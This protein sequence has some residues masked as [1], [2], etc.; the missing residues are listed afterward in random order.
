MK[1]TLQI[2]NNTWGHTARSCRQYAGEVLRRAAPVV[3]MVVMGAGSAWGQILQVTGS[4]QTATTTSTTLTINKPSGLAVGD[5]MFANIIQTDNDAGTGLNTNAS[6]SGW[7]V[8]AGNQIG[9][10]GNNEWWGTL[11]YKIADAADVMAANFAFT[12]DT[13][14]NGDGSAGGIV[15]FSGVDTGFPFDAV[16]PGVFNTTVSDDLLATGITTTT[17][18][19]AV[20]MFGMN[21]ANETFGSWTTTAPGALAEVFEQTFASGASMGAAAAWGTL[22]T[23]GATGNGTAEMSDNDNDPNGALLIALRPANATITSP[24]TPAYGGTFTVPA[25][26]T[27]V[28]V[29]AWGGGGGGG[30]NDTG[31][32]SGAD[33]AGGGGGGGYR[34]GVLIVSPGDNITVAIGAAGAG[35]PNTTN[36]AGTAGG[37]STVTHTSGVI[38]ANGGTAGTSGTA[39]GTGGGGSFSGTVYGQ[40]AFAGG[41][42]GGGDAN[43]GGGGGGSAGS[44]GNGGNGAN[45]TAGT[46]GAGGGAAGGAGGDDGAGTSGSLPGG[47]GGGAGDEGGGGG[48][49]AYGQVILTWGSLSSSTAGTITSGSPASSCTSPFNPNNISGDDPAGA[50]T[51]SWQSSTDGGT[52]W[53][54]IGGATSASYDPGNITATTQYRRL[55]SVSGECP[56]ISNVVTYSVNT[57]PTA[58]A[59]TTASV[60]T[61]TPATIAGNPTGGSGMYTTHAWTITNAGGTGATNGA[62]LT[63]ANQET[64]TFNGTGLTAGTVTLQY[65][66]TDNNGCTGTKTVAV[67]V[68]L[69]LAITGVSICAGGSGSLAVTSACADVSGSEGPSFAGTGTNVTGVGTVAWTNPGNIVSDNGSSATASRG[70]DG[71]VTT[72]YLQG[73]NLGFTIPSGA[74]INGIQV[75]M[76]RFASVSSGSDNV[77]DNI[78]RLIKAGTVT[79][80][81]KAVAGNWATAT[82]TVVSYGGASDLWGTTWTPAQIN[83]S[84]FGAALS[85]NITR[86]NGIVTGSVD[87]ISITVYYTIDHTIS[88]YTVSSGGTAVQTESSLTT[89]NPVGDAEV[90]MAGAPYSSLNN[91]NT[92][93]TYTFWAEC[94]LYPDCRTAVDFVINPGPSCSITGSDP[95]CANSTGH[96]YMGSGGGTYSWSIAGNG[97]INGSTTNPTVT[98]DAGTAGTYTVTLTVTNAGCTSSC[99]KT[100]TV[101][102]NPTAAIGG[103]LSF[104][105]GSST[106]LTA[107]GGTSYLWDDNSTNAMRTISAAG[108]YTVQVTDGNGCTDTETA[109]VTQNAAPAAVTASGAGTFCGSTTITADNGG[110]GTIYFQGTTSGGMSTANA[111][112]SEV[113]TSSGTY[114]FRARSADGCW[115]TEGSVTVTINPLPTANSCNQVNDLCQTNSGTID[116]KASG[117]TPSYSVTWTPAHGM[118]QPQTITNSG[119]MITITG[120]QGGTNYT[121]VVKDANNCQAP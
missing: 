100:V 46:A 78:V 84:N 118:S 12:L 2:W 108:T 65:T 59:P 44:A 89:F 15:A 97:T 10:N 86:D 60:C 82:G 71:T 11:L 17:N 80:D 38:T 8:I 91:T 7:T 103:A 30:M 106:T 14:A 92:P 1:N 93:G 58:G 27:C 74:T 52:T 6:R 53:T 50:E 55:R 23:A 110:D 19:A 41:A 90:L 68:S 64:V 5:I 49:G 111:S 43:E 120:L 40:I 87:Y 94:S 69:S 21:A 28:R 119:D 77:Q 25:G 73:T 96:V 117:G 54:T 13:D 20:V 85:A 62:N 39:G 35:A 36:T 61:G 114:Y 79:G 32:G 48:N 121:F 3:V 70:T 37:N 72:N 112:A 75:S 105:A 63:N 45:L 113:V 95:V 102:T 18:N 66:V 31:G 81:N 47:G 104:C 67:T 83:A 4:P 22:A 9:I 99:S 56:G 24:F 26:V 57:P 115:G 34:E 76:N 16:P 29:Q 116:I 98:V 51:W 101:N 109:T 88:W 33:G 42:G 107:S